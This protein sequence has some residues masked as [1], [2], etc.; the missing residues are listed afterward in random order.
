V[1]RID[2][3]ILQ[4]YGYTERAEENSIEIFNLLDIVWGNCVEGKINAGVARNL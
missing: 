1:Y 3:K 4:W 2:N